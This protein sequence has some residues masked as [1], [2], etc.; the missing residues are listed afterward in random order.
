MYG[1]IIWQKVKNEKQEK[2]LTPNTTD[3]MSFISD[4]ELTHKTWWG[5][6]SNLQ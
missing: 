1:K 2:T 5:K 3:M 6:K 4:E